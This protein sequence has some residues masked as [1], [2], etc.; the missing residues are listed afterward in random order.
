LLLDILRTFG[1]IPIP[2]ADY[3][4]IGSHMD[5]HPLTILNPVM[6]KNAMALHNLLL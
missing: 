6:E 1:V 4:A 2:S 3:A 5:C